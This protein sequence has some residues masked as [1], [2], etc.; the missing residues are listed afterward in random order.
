MPEEYYNFVT[1]YSYGLN[2]K[3]PDFLEKIYGTISEL[4][5]KFS[6]F[7][8]SEDILTDSKLNYKLKKILDKDFDDFIY[9]IKKVNEYFGYWRSLLN[10]ILEYKIREVL[11]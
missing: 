11:Y 7:K 10:Y 4:K 1:N 9:R 5:G 3:N 6:T 8:I 2:E